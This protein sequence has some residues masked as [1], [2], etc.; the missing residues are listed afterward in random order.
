MTPTLRVTFVAGALG[1]ALAMPTAAQAPLLP[2]RPD[3]LKFATIGDSGNGE[4]PQ[5]EVGRQMA[6]Q[7]AS[8]PFDLV[9]MVGDNLYGNQGAADY[10]KKFELPYKVLLDS[11][12]VFQAVLGNH[13]SLESRSYRPFNMNGERYYTFAKH[14]VRFIA[15]D[16]NQL[17]AKQLAWIDA[18]LGDARE[19]WKICYFHHPLY[20][21]A[22]RHGSA[23]DVRVLLEPM[24]VEH[25][26][27][28]VFSGHD[29]VYE[30]IKPQK[31]ITYFV[32]G[33]SG[34][35]RKGGLGRSDLTAAGFDQDR[36]FM[37]VEIAGG[38]MFFETISRA[39][40]V[41]DAGVI[42]R[43]PRVQTTDGTRGGGQ[44]RP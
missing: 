16:T 9:L 44:G 15:I 12:V 5:Y 21:G 38:E 6:A 36:A 2:N 27:N 43:R 18:T 8:F 28:A 26:V 40:S 7:R 32:I 25:G 23:V 17:D 4:T 31:G 33:S 22:T 10:V 30:R 3:S 42:T 14:D 1:W 20:S 24:L 41:V 19:P 37:L 34:Q 13:D 11:G 29:H 35:L 39:G